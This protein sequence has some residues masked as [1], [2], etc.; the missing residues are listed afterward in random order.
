MIVN[1]ENIQY[2]ENEWPYLWLFD[3]TSAATS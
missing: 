3:V 2:K 1:G